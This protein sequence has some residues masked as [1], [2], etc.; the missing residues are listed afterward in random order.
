M[1]TILIQAKKLNYLQVRTFC[2]YE[3]TTLDAPGL[4]LPLSIIFWPHL[5]AKKF[6]Y[7][8]IK[9]VKGTN[10]FMSYGAFTI[11]KLLNK[12]FFLVSVVLF[13]NEVSL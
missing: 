10:L 9:F 3:Y 11:C 13:S 8:C 4:I 2:R 12:L 6:Y 5:C 7:T 1:S